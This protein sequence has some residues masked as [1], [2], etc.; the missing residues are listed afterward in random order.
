MASQR[1]VHRGPLPHRLYACA[2]STKTDVGA[3]DAP[4]I[5][6]STKAAPSAAPEGAKFSWHQ[7]W[8]PIAVEA[9]LDA[10]K[11]TAAMLLGIPLVIWKDGSGQWSVLEDRCPHRLAPL[12][13]GRV[14]PSDG[15]L[16]CV[17]HGWRFDAAGKCRDIPQVEDDK[18]RATACG[19]SRACVRSFPCQAKAG[20]LWVWPDAA[21]PPPPDAQP[22]VAEELG[23]EGWTLLGGDWF[24]RDLEYS[25]DTLH[26]NLFDPSHIPFAHHK[27]MGSAT[28]DKATPLGDIKTIT[29]ISP[30]GFKLW[31]DTAPFRIPSKME[32]VNNFQPPALNNSV[33]T[34]ASG[35]TFMLQFYG[36]PTSPG[37][38]R[39]FAGFI[40]NMKLPPPAKALASV[41]PPWVFHLGQQVVLD[42]DAFLLHVQERLLRQSSGGWRRNFYLPATADTGVIKFRSWF[43]EVGGGSI[44][45]PPGTPTDLG[46]VLPREV[47]MDRYRQHVKSCKSCSNAVKGIERLQALFTAVATVSASIG[48]G[49][50]LQQALA[51]AARPPAAAE[52]VARVAAAAALSGGAGAQQG[53]AWALGWPMLLLCA[54]A[55]LVRYKLQGLW[56]RFHFTDYV[57][58]DVA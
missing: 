31:R 51:A 39:L 26:E 57:H 53:A 43:D 34:G 29:D 28:R 54:A 49:S 21:T 40:S 45:W 55:L 32:T 8:W 44:P 4:V 33:Q 24:Q 20:L 22:A 17:Y 9:Q 37:K 47:V 18:A 56:Q 15:S 41:I 25:Y 12:S 30:G 48:I 5:S 38:S 16:Q 3:T 50:L 10:G 2:A 14:E 6:E 52:T 36:V 1:R 19:S 13:E 42:S 35:R 7:Q 23:R 11:P 58:A 27:I 46:P